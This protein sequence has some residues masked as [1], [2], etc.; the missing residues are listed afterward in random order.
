VAS[1]G[2]AKGSITGKVYNLK[3]VSDFDGTYAAVG[4]DATIGGGKGV[5]TMKNQHGVRVDLVST[6]QGLE[7]TLGTSGI[8]MN[9]DHKSGSTARR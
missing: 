2:A 5:A 1:V 8:A 3:R 9:V 4:A 7:L 6:T